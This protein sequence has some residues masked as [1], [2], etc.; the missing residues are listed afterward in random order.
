VLVH[1]D[2]NLSYKRWQ[3]DIEHTNNTIT[4]THSKHISLIAEIN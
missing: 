2:L 4:A 1:V 3:R